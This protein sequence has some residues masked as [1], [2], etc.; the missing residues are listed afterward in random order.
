MKQLWLICC[1]FIFF[2]CQPPHNTHEITLNANDFAATISPMLQWQNR[3]LV[4]SKQSSIEKHDVKKQTL[5][6]SYNLQYSLRGCLSSPN[7]I[8]AVSSYQK[9]NQQFSIFHRIDSEKGKL[10]QK[11]TILGQVEFLWAIPDHEDYLVQTTIHGDSTI[12]SFV[13]RC[14]LETGATLWSINKKILTPPSVYKTPYACI[15]QL[16]N[17]HVLD[18]TRGLVMENCME[19]LDSTVRFYQQQA[20]SSAKKELN[21]HQ[22]IK[23]TCQLQK[24]GWTYKVELEET[25]VILLGNKGFTQLYELSSTNR[26]PVKE[27]ALEAPL[28]ILL[29]TEDG[30]LY[31]LEEEETNIYYYKEQ[32]NKKIVLSLAGKI[33]ENELWGASVAYH[34]PYIAYLQKEGSTYKVICENIAPSIKD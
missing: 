33:F 17:I 18:V 11:D 26:E 29:S 20:P 24:K 4:I 25:G 23:G 14:N 9:N 21:W 7:I 16:N 15:A 5:E 31:S 12:S 30:Y 1:S 8:L 22:H 32:A 6:W 3:Y 34:Y 19:N 27:L 10:L 2:Q 28:Q 13:Q